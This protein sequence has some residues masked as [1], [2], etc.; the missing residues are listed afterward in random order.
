MIIIKDINLA[1]KKPLITNGNMQIPYG[2]TVG[3]IGKSGTGKTSL[4]QEIGLLT[5]TESMQYTFDEI[6]INTCSKEIKTIL[7][8]NDISF[9]FQDIH[10]FNKLTVIDNITFHANLAGKQIEKQEI[11][12]LLDFVNLDI[13]LVSDLKTMS[14]GELQRLAIVC[15]L[16]K[17]AKLFIFDEPTAYLD[18]DN[19]KVIIDIISKLAHERNK[20][21]LVATHDKQVQES[22]DTMY[23]IEN[24]KL[25]LIKESTCK[26]STLPVD[27]N[28]VS[29]NVLKQFIKT[30][31]RPTIISKILI[32]TMI[33]ILL[34]AIV[35]SLVYVDSFQEKT[36]SSLLELLHYQITVTHAKEK[37]ISIREQ[38]ELKQIYH[39]YDIYSWIPI[40]GNIKGKNRELAGVELR[41]YQANEI[42]SLSVQ[43]TTD[44]INQFNRE[45]PNTIYITYELYRNLNTDNTSF[46][47]N[48]GDGIENTISASKVL[49]PSID[50]GQRI[51]IP[52]T[53]YLQYITSLGIDL[54]NMPIP[55]LQ[56]P[57]KS[58][59][60]ITKVKEL[61]PSTF[62]IH[63]DID[64]DATLQRVNFFNSTF[65]IG[66]ECILFVSL[67]VYKIYEMI[68]NKKDT[69]LLMVLGVDTKNMLYMK[70]YS[71]GIYLL[72]ITVVTILCTT[73]A[74]LLF[75]VF[76]IMALLKSSIIILSIII[77]VLLII[78]SFHL[79]FIKKYP[80]SLLLRS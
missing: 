1:F 43:H 68:M 5:Y 76:T 77:L 8:K 66:I 45:I 80:P 4:L 75:N 29:F 2:N 9:I 25:S 65:L 49:K 59:E 41:P 23:R 17:D 28:K 3:L 7:R 69:A 36:G 56:I 64:L 74:L 20:M 39:E 60:D 48:I 26:D 18:A 30:I 37:V 73:V 13:D 11:H 42:P 51:Y 79:Y 12:E 46:T 21:V 72:M 6:N 27:K 57:V 33:S 47:F 24:Q 10:L 78:I 35:L 71:E 58:I 31:E 70:L 22:L 15:G 53:I 32:G 67:L 19:K 61:L 34:S 63:S 50:I 38:T 52:Y 55:Q 54:I 16:V 40:S 14:G 44:T 62:K